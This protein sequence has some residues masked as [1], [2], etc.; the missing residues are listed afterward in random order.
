V[1][2]DDVRPFCIKDTSTVLPGQFAK[3]L[4][5]QRR[6]GIVTHHA[7]NI[8]DDRLALLYSATKL[9]TKDFFD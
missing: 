4:D 8:H 6:R 1:I 2:E 7:V 3:R 5:C 9:V